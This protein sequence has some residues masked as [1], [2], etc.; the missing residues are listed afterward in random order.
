MPDGLF[1]LHH[2]V[3]HLASMS[4]GS[5]KLVPEIWRGGGQ[6]QGYSSSYGNR[7]TDTDW[8]I[9]IVAHTSCTLIAGRLLAEAKIRGEPGDEASRIL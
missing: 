7:R 4:I 5:L 2:L 1:T 8:C 6:G 9:V 3:T